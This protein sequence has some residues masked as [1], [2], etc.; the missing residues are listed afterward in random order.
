MHSK[1]RYLYYA[2][3]Y[4]KGCKL[5]RGL[6]GIN[7]HEFIYYYLNSITFG[8]TNHQF[9]S[10]T[11]LL[12]YYCFILDIHCKTSRKVRATLEKV[13]YLTT[14]NRYKNTELPTLKHPCS[15]QLI[16]YSFPPPTLK[17]KGISE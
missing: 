14:S 3:T 4:K 6:R 15:R 7:Q 5:N 8:F 12:N 1:Y 13:K 11:H 9:F 10:H 2:Y 17:A 16:G